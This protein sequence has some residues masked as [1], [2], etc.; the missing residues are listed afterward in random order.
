MS[1]S[2]VHIQMGRRNSPGGSELGCLPAWTLWEAPPSKRDQRA[3]ELEEAEGARGGM[4]I[5]RQ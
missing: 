5:R 2:G 1:F 3:E 4:S